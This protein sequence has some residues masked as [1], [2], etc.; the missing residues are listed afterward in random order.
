[1]TEPDLPITPPMR[2]E[3]QRRRKATWPDGTGSGGGG[4]D[5]LERLE[6]PLVENG[7]GSG[8]ERLTGGERKVLPIILSLSLSLGIE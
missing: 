4:L 2:E 6:D 7:L 3:L 1:M 8:A 5:D